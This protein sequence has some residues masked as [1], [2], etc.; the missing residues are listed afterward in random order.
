MWL[1]ENHLL[2]SKEVNLFIVAMEGKVF[3]KF[4]FLKP[5]MLNLASALNHGR[6]KVVTIYVTEWGKW[7]ILFHILCKIYFEYNFI[8]FWLR[9]LS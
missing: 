1:Q 6:L 5:L 3:Y 9:F 4:R 8:L 2:P 7:L